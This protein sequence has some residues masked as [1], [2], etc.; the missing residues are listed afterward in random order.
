MESATVWDE[1]DEAAMQP[2]EDRPGVWAWLKDKLDLT[3]YR[4]QAAA[5]VV[6]S[7]LKGREGTYYVLKNPETKT[8]YRLGERDHFLV[9]ADGRGADGQGPRGGLLSSNTT[10]S[11]LAGPRNW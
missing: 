1:L 2:D 4:P 10:P 3:R 7:K 6:S 9:A 5:G 8:Y 11:P